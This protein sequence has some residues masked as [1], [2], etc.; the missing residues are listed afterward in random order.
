MLG[1]R[2]SREGARKQPGI[3]FAECQKNAFAETFQYSVNPYV[4]RGKGEC[5]E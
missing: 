4:A 5:A 3:T 1:I 2:D